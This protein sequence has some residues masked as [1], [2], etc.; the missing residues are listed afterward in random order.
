MVILLLAGLQALP[1]EIK[2]AAKVDGATGWQSF[3]EITFPLMLPVSITAVVLRTIFELK[4]ADI[5]INVT[6]GGPGG[7]TDTISSFVYREY[8]DRSNV[9][10]GDDG[11]RGLSR[12]NH[13]LHHTHPECGQP[14]HAENDMRRRGQ[15]GELAMTVDAAAEATALAERDDAVAPRSL[16]RDFGAHRDLRAADRLDH[17]RALPH[18]LDPFD[19]DQ[20]RTRRHPGPSH[21]GD[22]LHAGLEGMAVA[23]ACRPTPSSP[24][25]TSARSSSRNSS[26]AS[27]ARSARLCLRVV[28]GSLAAYGLSRFDYKFGP[29]RNKDISFFFISQLILPPV[30]LALPFLV[31]YKELALLDTRIGLILIYTLMVMPIV[32]WVMRD[33]FDSIPMEMEQAALV[34]GCTIWGAFLRI[35]LP[36]ALPGHGR[37]FHPLAGPLLERI[38]LRFA[39]YQ[40]RRADPAGHGGEPDGIAGD[41]LVDDRRARDG[42]DHAASA[43]RHFPRALHRHGLDCRIR[44]VGS[45]II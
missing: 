40:L 24:P 19:L 3:W 6:A 25:P 21:S 11:G 29:W 36:I 38:F 8:R 17:Y 15:D 37:G 10:Y 22:R 42:G 30:V 12:H 43:H 5:V 18:L 16:L 28:I 45:A 31:L 4:L 26:T 33:Q 9:G 44:E 41:Q 35:V 27:S 32:I 23:R 14:L 34:D 1:H 13:R 39:P 2:E 7:A 20:A